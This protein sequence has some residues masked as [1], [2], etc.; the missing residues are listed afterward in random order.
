VQLSFENPWVLAFYVIGIVTASWHFAY[1]IWL[2]AAKWGI[3][4]GDRA[5]RRF[6]YVCVLIAVLFIA[7]GL[8]TI[9]AF[10]KW[11]RQPLHPA[12]EVATTVCA[13]SHGS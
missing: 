7:V 13:V 4:V 5:R 9:R 10:F 3:T 11:P 12:T 6:G 1:G 8:A 2:F